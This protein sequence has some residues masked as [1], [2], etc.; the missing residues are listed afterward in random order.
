MITRRVILALAV[1]VSVLASCGGGD[2]APSDECVRL[3][4]E[5]KLADERFVQY[6]EMG[7]RTVQLNIREQARANMEALDCEGTPTTMYQTGEFTLKPE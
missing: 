1:G 7:E 2:I 6:Q 5:Y 3:L 4:E